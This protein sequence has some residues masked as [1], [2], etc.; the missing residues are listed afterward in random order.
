MSENLIMHVHT[1]VLSKS[2]QCLCNFPDE[3][4]PYV[5]T[6]VVRIDPHRFLAGCR[7]RRLNQALSVLSVSIGFLVCTG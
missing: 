5:G 4:Q 7:E 6:W 1:L 2:H 3:Q